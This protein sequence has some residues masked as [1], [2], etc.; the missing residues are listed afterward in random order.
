[1]TPHR[2]PFGTEELMAFLRRGRMWRLLLEGAAM[3][4]SVLMLTGHLHL[5]LLG[6]DLAPFIGAV[7]GLAAVFLIVDQLY[8]VFLVRTGRI[9][10]RKLVC[11]GKASSRGREKPGTYLL[12]DGAR[13]R[14]SSR[15]LLNAE[16]GDRFYFVFFRP[17]DRGKYDMIVSAKAVELSDDLKKRVR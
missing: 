14:A 4:V 12:F 5:E 10:L 17:D 3:A 6:F 13:V 8:R 2:I 7:L 9:C 16:P 15:M 11:R 1:M